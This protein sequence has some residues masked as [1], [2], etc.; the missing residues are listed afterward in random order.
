M[1][2][3]RTILSAIAIA[4]TMTLTTTTAKAHSDHD[5]STVAYKWAMS[6]NLKAKLDSRID[7]AN[8]TSL[9][10][11]NPLEQKKLQHYDIKVGNKFNTENRGINF[12]MERTSAGMKIVGASRV[13]KVS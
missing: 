12:L 2:Q 1:K 8:P 13:G 10:G 9:I 6:K 5:H 4:A 3:A 11:L 7:S